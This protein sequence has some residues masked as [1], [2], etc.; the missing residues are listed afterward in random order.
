MPH[1]RGTTGRKPVLFGTLLTSQVIDL[2]R[3]IAK[4][5][6]AQAVLSRSRVPNDNSSCTSAPVARDCISMTRFELRKQDCVAGMSRL[7]EGTVDLVVTS[8]PYNLGII[9]GKYSDRQD[10]RSYLDWCDKWARQV[11][12]VM[13]PDGSFFLNVGAAPSSPMLP[14]EIVIT[15]RD[16]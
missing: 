15:L 9:Y 2:T 14:H 8:P 10:R 4:K 11:R 12:R 6:V 1:P 5:A 13:K 7:G 3:E 16:Y